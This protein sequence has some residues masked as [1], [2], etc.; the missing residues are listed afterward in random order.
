M[1]L[2][3]FPRKFAHG[4]KVGNVDVYGELY[5]WPD[6]HF[7]YMVHSRNRDPLSGG[8]INVSFALLDQQHVLLGTYGMPA[9]QA[10]SVA[11]G[12]RHDELFGKVPE[13]KL[14]K[15]GAVALLFRP[16]DQKLDA[17]GVQALA[18]AGSELVFCPTPD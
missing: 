11:A 9:D 5:L 12:Q 7:Q 13:D 2:I 18:T 4:Q 6:G 16:H 17:A 8:S 3:A 15:T 1:S 14:K 10:W